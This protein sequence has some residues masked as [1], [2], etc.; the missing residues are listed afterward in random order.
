MVYSIWYVISGNIVYGIWYMIY[1]DPTNLV[2]GIPPYTGP[3]NQDV[4]SLCLCGLVG[5]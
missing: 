3:W 1:K 4:R 2:S 5:P